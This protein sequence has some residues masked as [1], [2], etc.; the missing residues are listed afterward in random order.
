MGSR[1][2]T[3]IRLFAVGLVLVGL[4]TYDGWGVSA[5]PA[6]YS[7]PAA[8]PIVADVQ[9]TDQTIRFLEARL[10]IDPEN[11][12]ASNMLAGAYLQRVRE[13]GNVQ[14][15]ERAF[16]AAHASLAA[17]PVEQNA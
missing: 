4:K 2:A 9:G 15:L 13:T 16:H 10:S 6:A 12:H 3:L 5:A 1:N 11:V 14:D 8:A 17:V 7:V